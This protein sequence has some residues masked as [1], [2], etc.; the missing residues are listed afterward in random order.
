M[1]AYD[2]TSTNKSKK[3]TRAFYKDLNLDF[4]RN[5]VT[6]DVVKIEDL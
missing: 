5:V 2:A 6:N 4:T 3:S 1:A